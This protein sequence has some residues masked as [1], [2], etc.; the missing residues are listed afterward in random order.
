MYNYTEVAPSGYHVSRD[1]DIIANRLKTHNAP[2]GWRYL[3]SGEMVPTN[4]FA[5][6]IST[7]GR[8]TN[9][10]AVWPSF[11]AKKDPFEEVINP[12]SYGQGR[13]INVRDWANVRD[14]Y[15]VSAK[16]VAKPPAGSTAHIYKKYSNP[17][18]LD[19]WFL[20]GFDD[21]ANADGTWK[22]GHHKGGFISQ[23]VFEEIVAANRPEESISAEQQYEATKTAVKDRAKRDPAQAL[24][25]QF[26]Q[27]KFPTWL[28]I[29]ALGAAGIL[30]YKA[31]KPRPR[32]GRL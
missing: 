10:G 2:L 5:T 3:E 26:D 27:N 32:F 4:H 22:A 12:D 20:I 24:L 31:L 1:G 9:L 21:Q 18:N 7:A 23:E 15:S 6:P 11:Q 13:V 17:K 28:K 8:P 19:V 14:A 30:T 29:S 25:I 16:V